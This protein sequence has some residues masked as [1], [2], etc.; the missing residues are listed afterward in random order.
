MCTAGVYPGG[1]TVVGYREEY[2]LG[3]VHTWARYT[4]S[5][6]RLLRDS[7]QTR[8]SENNRESGES[9][10]SREG[11][12]SGKRVI[13]S[14]VAILV[15]LS[16]PT[17]VSP[18]PWNNQDSSSSRTTRNNQESSSSEDHFWT[19]LGHSWTTFGLLMG[20]W[21]LFWAFSASRN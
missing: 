14:T 10:K 4:S 21:R 2:Y 9:D 18:Q 11:G 6:N 16:L 8:E 1:Y 13:L 12:E 5:G 7:A 19:T 3:R 20:S 15:I 17:L